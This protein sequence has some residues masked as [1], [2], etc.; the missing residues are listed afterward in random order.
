MLVNVV[1]LLLELGCYLVMAFLK[2]Q[3]TFVGMFILKSY[4]AY[5]P[6]FN[7]LLTGYIFVLTNGNYGNNE[8]AMKSYFNKVMLV[9]LPIILVVVGIT[10]IVPLQ[11]VSEAPKFYTY[12]TCT[13]AI[14]YSFGLLFPIW[15][16]RCIY[17][18]FKNK[19]RK[20]INARI[21]LLLVG[22]VVVA[23]AGG[24][25]QFVDRSILILT[26]AHSIMLTLIYFTIENP[27]LKMLNQLNL[28]MAQTEKSNRA[29]EDF[30]ASMSHEIR[31]PLNA[32][33]GFSEDIQEHRDVLPQEIVEDADY[34]IEASKV[35]VDIVGNILDINKL[36]AN[37]IRITETNYD[38]R[39]EIDSLAKAAIATIGERPIE[40]KLN[41]ASNVPYELY[42]D[43]VH[44]KQIIN[45]IISNAIKYTDEGSIELSV[46][47]ANNMT[48]SDLTISIKDT[49]KG[50]KDEDISKLFTKF[51]RLDAPINSTVSGTGLGLYITK[52]LLDMMGGEIEV[53]SEVGKGSIFTVTLRQTIRELSNPNENIEDA[54]LDKTVMKEIKIERPTLENVKIKSHKKVLIVDDNRMNIKVARKA[55]QDF[56]FDIDECYDGLQCLDKIK[57]GNEYDLILMDIMMPNMD[58]ETAFKELNKIPDFKIPVL[59]VTADVVDGAEDR[60]SD[61]GFAGYIAKPFNKLQI[62]DK[63][64]D[65]FEDELSNKGN[66][67]YLRKNGFDIDSGLKILHT[68]ENYNETL[69]LF[70]DDLP[71]SLDK[72]EKWKAEDQIRYYWYEIYAVRMNSIYLG[73]TKLK[74]MVI[75][76]EEKAKAND[77][78]YVNNHHQEII[79]EIVRIGNVIKNYL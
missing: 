8:Y 49:G 38:L 53:K 6:I 73:L 50:I 33:V 76:Q 74:E 68:I 55:L 31:T 20:E 67:E 69:K 11:Y 29:K 62:Q 40:F 71:Q 39:K 43:K 22:A 4:I 15:I 21:Y 30:L 23:S 10:Y 51:E 3:D 9:F 57:L 34:I 64:N 17:S 47:A 5:I 63:L 56:S 52:S 42:G 27:D 59:A 26:T 61:M 18:T 25:T 14:F 36:D 24:L 45:N 41:I 48:D 54:L 13:T 75:N 19:A 28:A 2:I 79:D 35:L 37:E 77:I 1:G 32:I 44:I 7:W 70:L 46:M 72:I 16:G 12:G 60:Y 66:I 78:E 65:I 58:G